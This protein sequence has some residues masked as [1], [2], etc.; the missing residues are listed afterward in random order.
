MSVLHEARHLKAAL[1][2]TSKDE[3]CPSICQLRVTGEI[4]EATD[5]HWMLRIEREDVLDR[6]LGKYDGC[7]AASAIK[8]IIRSRPA[9]VLFDDEDS[10]DSMV[11]A[12][13]KDGVDLVNSKPSGV[14]NFPD[15][16]QVIK[17]ANDPGTMRHRL[18]ISPDLM[19]AAMKAM[20]TAGARTAIVMPLRL[21][22]E[23]SSG[24]AK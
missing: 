12:R 14:D 16:D 8:N 5:G 4:I 11:V 1:L 21:S 18:G 19:I 7:A 2:A 17:L 22:E 9:R 15:I 23:S 13:D 6:S 3:T 24:G 10:T 20:K